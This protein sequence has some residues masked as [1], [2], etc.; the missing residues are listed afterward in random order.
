MA[1]IK[2]ARSVEGVRVVSVAA[3]DPLR[4][5]AFARAQGIPRSHESY[6]SLLADPE[7]DAVYVALPNGL[8]AGWTVRALVAGKHVLCEKPFTANAAEAEEVARVARDRGLVVS[9]GFAYRYHP[10]AARMREI[11]GSGEIG[12][13][14]HLEA[15]FRVPQPFRGDI[16]YQLNLAGGATMDAG[17][18][19]VSLI[20]FLAGAEPEVTRASAK[21][22]SPD[23]DRMMSADLSFSDGRTARMVCSLFSVVPYRATVAVRGTEGE[24]RV[25]NPYHPHWFH[26]L[27][28]RGRTGTRHEHLAGENAYALHLRAFAGEILRREAAAEAGAAPD[29]ARKDPIGLS[30]GPEDAIG[31]MKV[32]DAIYERA[33]LRRRSGKG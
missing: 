27:T 6:E 18:Y 1:V 5:L 20:R 14:R 26:R 21:L 30:T 17:C 4:A 28:V 3:R 25:L 7:I 9:E 16:R 15:Q 29:P 31:T 2:P 19:A 13:V 32:I 8:H 11:L 33:G 23:V 12:A 10:L 22:A 24:L